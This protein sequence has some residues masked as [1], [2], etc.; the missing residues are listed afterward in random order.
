VGTKEKILARKNLAISREWKEIKLELY[1]IIKEK[2]SSQT[3][4]G[5]FLKG[6]LKTIFIVD[7]WV[8]DFENL[9]NKEERGV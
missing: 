4:N 5:D 8:K 1:E 9:K 3:M 2:G 7:D 6:M